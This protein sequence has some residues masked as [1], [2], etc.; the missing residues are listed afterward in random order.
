MAAGL[1]LTF[2]IFTLTAARVLDAL[3][4]PDD[5]LRTLGIAL[6]ALAGIALLVPA[7]AE[8]AGRPFQPL[9]RAG[10]TARTRRGDGFAGGVAIGAAL[11]LVWT[12]CAGPVLAAVSVLA[13]NQDVS[14][15]VVAITLAYAFGAALPAARHRPGRTARHGAHP[16]AA[17]ARAGAAARGRGDHGRGRRALRDRRPRAPGRGAARLHERACR[18][19]SAATARRTSWTT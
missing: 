18:R 2:T 15:R 12:P 7:V 6:L 9:A 13:A 19:S 3:G 16:G 17:R 8:L 14:A 1:V 10:G 4:L 5:A 11:G